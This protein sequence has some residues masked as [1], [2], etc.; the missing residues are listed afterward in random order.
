MP[1]PDLLTDRAVSSVVDSA[2]LM[3]GPD[4]G[5]TETIANPPDGKDPGR[6]PPVETGLFPRVATSSTGGVD[7]PAAAAPFGALPDPGPAAFRQMAETL[8]RAPD[9]QMDLI[10]SPEELGRLRMTLTPGDTGISVVIHA[11]R[12]DT[13]DLMRRNIDML[14]Q[15]FRDLGYRDIRFDFGQGRQGAG[16]GQPPAPPPQEMVDQLNPGPAL[17]PNTRAPLADGLDIRI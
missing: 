14:S 5:A 12:A 10:L 13:M 4:D 6:P 8:H 3:Q 7:R 1:A 15:E 2:A 16:Q 17:P 11:D 9:G